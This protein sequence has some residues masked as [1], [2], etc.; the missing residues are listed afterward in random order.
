M[1]ILNMFL[2]FCFLFIVCTVNS[3]QPVNEGGFHAP[4]SKGGNSIVFPP[5]PQQ[6][7]VL[8][9]N[10][11][12][13]WI[14]VV[15]LFGACI[16]LSLPLSLCMYLALSQLCEMDRIAHNPG[17]SQMTSKGQQANIFVHCCK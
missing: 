5:F 13:D 10:H 15:Q 12:H 11:N 8:S 1:L 14:T 7:P 2:L 16:S 3:E 9:L 4:P 6:G 17:I